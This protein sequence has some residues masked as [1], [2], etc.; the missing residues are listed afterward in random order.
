MGELIVDFITSLDGY[1]AAASSIPKSKCA[2]RYRQVYRKDEEP[3]RTSC[4]RRGALAR[5]RVPLV[6]FVD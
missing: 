1:A 2:V 4:T 6:T 5:T 3:V